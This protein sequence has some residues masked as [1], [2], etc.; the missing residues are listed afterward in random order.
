MLTTLKAI[1]GMRLYHQQLWMGSIRAREADCQERKW[2]HTEKNILILASPKFSM[3]ESGWHPWITYGHPQPKKLSKLV[4]QTENLVE[5]CHDNV[6]YNEEVAI[7]P[8]IENGVPSLL[9]TSFTEKIDGARRPGWRYPIWTAQ[10][11]G[12]ESLLRPK[13]SKILSW[14]AV[15]FLLR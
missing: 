13:V 6:L 3:I 10:G 1:R 2:V 12:E 14:V 7:L 15:V 4:L 5:E 8:T 11:R 9:E